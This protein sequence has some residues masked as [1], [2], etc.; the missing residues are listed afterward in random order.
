LLTS[1][2]F[3]LSAPSSKYFFGKIEIRKINFFHQKKYHG[4]VSMKQLF[5]AFPLL[6]LGKH[7][8]CHKKKK[9]NVMSTGKTFGT[10]IKKSTIKIFENV[11]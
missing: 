4:K 3:Y 6:I 8:F 5:S 7:F 9:K 1:E 10:N 11:I 2:P